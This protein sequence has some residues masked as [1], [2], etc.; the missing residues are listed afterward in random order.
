MAVSTPD[1]IECAALIA[2]LADGE[3]HSSAAL[4][5]ELGASRGRLRGAV[6]R[7]KGLGVEIGSLRGRGYRL[8]RAVELLDAARIREALGRER[9]ASVRRLEVLVEVDSTNS[10]LLAMSPPPTG[11]ADVCLCEIQSAGRGRRGRLWVS[12][13]GASIAM[14]L[15]WT[16]REGARAKP[17]L[18]LAVGVAISRALDRAGARDVRLKWPNDVWLADRKIGGVLVE[19]KAEA[20]GAAQVVIGIG[21]NLRLSAE[22]RRAIEAGGA[23]VA[24]LQDACS[25]SLSRNTLAAALLEELLR[26]LEGFEAEGFAPFRAEWLALDALGGRAARV[27]GEQGGIAGIARGVDVDGALLLEDG[28][29]LHRF[30]SGE[31]SLRLSEGD[32]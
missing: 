31:V 14:S 30:V 32:A 9:G 5:R 28:G 4:S 23:R 3:V 29:H 22:E 15:G 26:M 2:R 17:A 6:R 1:R 19:L 24:A 20:D 25:A 21:L 8:P 12:P 18:S 7:L 11:L 10:R 27:L 13:F 16:F